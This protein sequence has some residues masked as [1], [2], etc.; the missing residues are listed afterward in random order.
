MSTIKRLKTN[1]EPFK[2]ALTRSTVN[3]NKPIIGSRYGTFEHA[4][5]LCVAIANSY[6]Y[7]EFDEMSLE[8]LSDKYNCK[9][10]LGSIYK[11]HNY[12]DDGGINIIPK[13][14]EF[15][16]EMYV[17]EYWYRI[18]FTKLHNGKRNFYITYLHHDYYIRVIFDSNDMDHPLYGS[19]KEYYG[20]QRINALKSHK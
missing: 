17:D 20:I 5:T 4:M 16:Y 15:G 6:M 12:I 8:W 19:L 14:D 18:V 13:E 2:K 7:S 11:L 1:A 9:R 3:I 10:P